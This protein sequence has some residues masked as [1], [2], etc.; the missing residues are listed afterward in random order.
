[1]NLRTYAA[2][3]ALEDWVACFWTLTSEPDDTGVSS[4]Q[5]VLPD[6]FPELI[7]HL[8]APYERRQRGRVVQDPSAFVFGQLDEPIE[9]SSNQPVLAVGARLKPTALAEVAACAGRKL[10]GRAVA[11]DALWGRRGLALERRLRAVGD[12]ETALELL[13]Q[14]LTALRSRRESSHKRQLV[15]HAVRWIQHNQGRSPIQQL[16]RHLGYS[17]RH[18]ERLFGEHLGVSPKRYARLQ[19]FQAIQRAALATPDPDW[20]T[21]AIDAGYADQPHMIRE[22]RQFSGQSPSAF[23]R[24]RQPLA[25]ALLMR[26]AD[27][28]SPGDR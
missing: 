22:L 27:S 20:Q 19:R 21:L 1:M 12:V 28:H 5:R 2:P 23:V 9:L 16:I 14:E 10:T 26:P 3:K 4:S 8:G 7:V 13:A 11:L 15:E 25:Q 17:R 18:I 6:G 24:S